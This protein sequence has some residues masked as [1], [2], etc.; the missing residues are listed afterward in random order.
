MPRARFC[1]LKKSDKNP[2]KPGPIAQPKSP[3]KAIRENIAVPPFGKALQES[4]NDPG[5]IIPT[6]NPQRAHPNNEKSGFL[7]NTVI[8]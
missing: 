6:D 7:E 5:H 4:E 2:T 3:E 1:L 8:P